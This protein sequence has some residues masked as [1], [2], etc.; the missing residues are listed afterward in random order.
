M[1]NSYFQ[2]NLL[3]LNGAFPKLHIRFQW[4]A[5]R[6]YPYN[7]YLNIGPYMSYQLVSNS[8][9]G[10]DILDSRPHT[11]TW[12]INLIIIRKSDQLAIKNFMGLKIISNIYG[13]KNY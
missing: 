9:A 13:T 3:M 1:V 11:C 2:H 6:T 5:K 12:K 10:N 7:S 4:F 8:E